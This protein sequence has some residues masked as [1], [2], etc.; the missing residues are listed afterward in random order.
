MRSGKQYAIRGAR[1]L[2]I[3]T[4][5]LASAKQPSS[6]ERI[7]LAL[8]WQLQCSEIAAG[9]RIVDLD[10]AAKSGTSRMPAREAL[11]QLANEGYLVGTTRGFMIPVLTVQEV[12]ESF[13]VRKLLEPRAAGN[14]ARDLDQAAASALVAAINGARAALSEHNLEKLMSSMIAFRAS[15][16]GAVRN[17]R[18]HSVIASFAEHVQTVRLATLRD[19][20]AQEIAVQGLEELGRAF[21]DHDPITASDRMTAHIGAAEQ[22]FYRLADRAEDRRPLVNA[23]SADLHTPRTPRGK[24]AAV[25]GDVDVTSAHLRPLE[26]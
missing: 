19:L 13:E 6:R 14:V 22:I 18:L 17:P 1:A 26:A 2:T 15:W 11:L 7:Y 8:R 23:N 4:E 5:K 12:G 3:S 10:I 24:P 9:E 16:L 25:L 20:D 21:L